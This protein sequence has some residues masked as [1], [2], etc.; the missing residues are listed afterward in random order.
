MG[1]ACIIPEKHRERQEEGFYR[2]K[3]LVGH[4]PHL[5]TW[6]HSTARRPSG[7]LLG[8]ELAWV[9]HALTPAGGVYSRIPALPE[10]RLLHSHPSSL[11]S[12]ARLDSDMGVPTVPEACGLRCGTLLLAL[13]LTASR[14]KVCRRRGAGEERLGVQPGRVEGPRQDGSALNPLSLR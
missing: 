12:L 14:G 3:W 13:F 10:P 7:A 2:G 5:S 9:T 1:T 11:S 6:R 4:L 8:G